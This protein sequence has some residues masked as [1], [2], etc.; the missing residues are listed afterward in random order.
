M[1]KEFVPAVEPTGVGAQEPLHPSHQVGVG[2]LDHEVKMVGH[3]AIGMHLP[4]GLD[5]ALP[6]RL[7]AAEPIR[8]IFENRLPP[9]SPVHHMI[10]RARI[11]HR[12]V[13]APCGLSSQG[14]RGTV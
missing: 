13:C 10:D 14:K 1:P 8:V 11:L 2:S 5:T 7:Q 9:I 6:Q 4:I 3:Q 12:Q